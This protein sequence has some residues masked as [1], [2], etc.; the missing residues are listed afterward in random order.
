M[1]RPKSEQKRDAI[2]S[3]AIKIIARDGLSASTA[4]ISKEAKVSNGTLFIYF[5]TKNVLLNELYI[6]IKQE[7]ANASMQ[8][9]SQNFSE[10]DQFHHLWINWTNWGVT[11]QEK[12]RVLDYLKVSDL[13]TAETKSLTGQ[14][15]STPLTIVKNI[16][17]QGSMKSC[18]FEYVGSLVEA[19][20]SS[21][22]DEMTK[23]PS[24]ALIISNWGFEAVWRMIS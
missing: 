21:T 23:Q 14:I 17:T 15:K 24:Q 20:A 16:Y 9:I 1:A 10:K 18:N 13:I 12:R 8:G 2:I 5:E 6:Q 7:I 22:M 19:L 3:A 4:D 11:N